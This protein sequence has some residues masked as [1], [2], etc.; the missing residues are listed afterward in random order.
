M[1]V[2][3]AH[4]WRLAVRAQAVWTK[5][6]TVA[7]GGSS[8]KHMG[9]ILLDQKM[10]KAANATSAVGAVALRGD[11]RGLPA[12]DVSSVQAIDLAEWLRRTATAADYVVMKMVRAFCPRGLSI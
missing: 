1:C 7:W 6:G 11:E 8:N 12:L 3:A 2:C 10:N 4:V 9:A 5:N